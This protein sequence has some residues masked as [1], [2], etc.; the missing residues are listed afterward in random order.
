MPPSGGAA[1][2]PSSVGLP[3]PDRPV[4]AAASGTRLRGAL[5]PAAK[6]VLLVAMVGFAGWA[7]AKNWPAVS[8][9]LKQLNVW[10][11]LLSLPPIALAMGCAMLVWRSLLADLG[12]PLPLA[13]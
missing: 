6:V 5:F 2:P 3:V 4:P 1:A 12:A 8:R 11:V 9:D 10:L 7:L 13:V